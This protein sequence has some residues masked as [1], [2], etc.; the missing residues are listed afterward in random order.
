MDRELENEV[1]AA[2]GSSEQRQFSELAILIAKMHNE[3][4]KDMKWFEAA[5]LTAIYFVESARTHD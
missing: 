3:L 4:R 2:M 5:Y 1:R